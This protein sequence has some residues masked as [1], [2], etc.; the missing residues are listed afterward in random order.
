M[1]GQTSK[2]SE[3]T[4]HEK[5]VI[6]RLRSLHLEDDY[7]EVTGDVEKGTLAPLMRPA[8]D[9]PIHVLESWRESILKDPKNK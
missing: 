4:T 5:A 6:E 2:P 3:P 1:G 9:L 8:E 7:V